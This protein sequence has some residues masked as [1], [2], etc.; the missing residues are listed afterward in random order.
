MVRRRES[1]KETAMF[2]AVHGGPLLGD[3]E[4]RN[5][6]PGKKDYIRIPITVPAKIIGQVISSVV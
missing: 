4:G 1:H 6:L 5:G 3:E 2:A